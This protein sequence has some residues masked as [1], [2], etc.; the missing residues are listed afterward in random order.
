MVK[1]IIYLLVLFYMINVTFVY[2]Q[3]NIINYNINDKAILKDSDYANKLCKLEFNNFCKNDNFVSFYFDMFAVPDRIILYNQNLD[4]IFKT[5]FIGNINYPI[6]N[7][8][9][10]D[11]NYISYNINYYNNIVDTFYYDFFD[12]FNFMF[13]NIDSFPHN[14]GEININ[15][16]ENIMYFELEFPYPSFSNMFLNI[17]ADTIFDNSL[18][19]VEKIDSVIICNY[20]DKPLDDYEII[21]IN[22]IDSIFITKYF[23]KNEITSNLNY[24]TN[25]HYDFF[26]PNAINYNENF[27]IYDPNQFIKKLNVIKIYDR[28]GNKKMEQYNVPFR[29]NNL[30]KNNV[31][32]I[33]ISYID[34][35]NNLQLYK[36]DITI[37]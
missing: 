28:W 13:Y 26:V 19:E 1:R 18:I 4:T 17:K 30:L 37:F 36:S 14:K 23:Y 3:N 15:Y 6:G 21:N 11:T 22:C 33:L 7:N 31:Y 9:I 25:C 35:N 12:N 10:L 16:K 5:N 24:D 8:Y 27:N 2:T 34:I 29:L 20:E 32:V